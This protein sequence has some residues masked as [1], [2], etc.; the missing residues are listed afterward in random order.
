[1][2][3]VLFVDWHDLTSIYNA[4]QLYSFIEAKQLRIRNLKDQQP[5]RILEEREKRSDCINHQQAKVRN[6]D[7]DEES[8]EQEFD[9]YLQRV[10]VCVI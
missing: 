6:V 3:T 4:K 5:V 2:S 8:D 7:E 10:R 1:M 9:P